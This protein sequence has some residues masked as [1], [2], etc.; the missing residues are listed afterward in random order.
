MQ[1]E[2][3]PHD[4]PADVHVEAFVALATVQPAI[5]IGPALEPRLEIPPNDPSSRQLKPCPGGN[6]MTTRFGLRQHRPARHLVASALGVASL[7]VT[8]CSTPGAAQ[9]TNADAPVTIE[10]HQTFISLQNRAGLPLTDIKLSVIPY[11]RTEFT[12]SFA[13]M[14]NGESREIS[15]SDL[16]S[17]DGTPFNPR[18]VKA[19]SV[20][21]SATDVVGKHYDLEVPWK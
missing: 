16:S 12:K 8:A 1:H 2:G 13:R 5:S 19:K 21:L 11:S 20:R 3:R 17:R 10:A 9:A 6:I 7:L 4:D 14:E 15:L 18:I